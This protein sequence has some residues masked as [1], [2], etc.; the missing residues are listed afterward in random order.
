MGS[1]GAE[2]NRPR[3][4]DRRAF[5][6]LLRACKDR[7]RLSA[8][9]DYFLIY[10][11]GRTGLRASELLALR[12]SDLSLGTDPAF[13]HV[14]TLKQRKRQRD[15]VLLEPRVVKRARTYLRRVLPKLLPIHHAD[16]PLFP[17]P[18]RPPLIERP[19]TLRNVSRIFAVYARRARLR[20]GISFHSLRHYRAMTLYRTTKGD[21][22]FVRQQLRHR[23][24]SSTQAY[25]GVDPEHERAYLSALDRRS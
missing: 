14:G 25:L 3:H 23:F 6:A 21:L 24:L 2:L 16:S 12:V 19:M 17:G 18:Q 22:E 4:L 11:A 8:R 13:V 10:L 5:L 15:Q 7:K 9:R 20:P 1:R